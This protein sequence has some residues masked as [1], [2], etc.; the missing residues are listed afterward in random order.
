MSSQTFDRYA[1]FDKVV[2]SSSTI[3]PKYHNTLRQLETILEQYPI[4]IL[5]TATDIG[6]EM[7]ELLFFPSIF[8]N[9]EIAQFADV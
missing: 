6:R 8:N 9:W 5:I 7:T 2:I 4:I 3:L 1:F